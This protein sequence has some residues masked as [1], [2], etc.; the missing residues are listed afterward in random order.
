LSYNGVRN[1]NGISEKRSR[2]GSS[3]FSDITKIIFAEDFSGGNFFSEFAKAPDN[4]CALSLNMDMNG[5]ALETRNDHVEMN[6]SKALHRIPL[7]D[8]LWGIRAS[9]LYPMGNAEVKKS[10]EGFSITCNF[11]A[12][13]GEE[14]RTPGFYITKELNAGKYLF[15]LYLAEEICPKIKIYESADAV[16]Y[17]GKPQLMHDT[18][19]AKYIQAEFTAESIVRIEI[20][21]E[22]EAAESEVHEILRPMLLDIGAACE[23]GADEN[24]AKSSFFE[25]KSTILE[26]EV[27]LPE[28]ESEAEAF[29]GSRYIFKRGEGL[30]SVNVKSGECFLEYPATAQYGACAIYRYGD[31]FI[32]VFKNGDVITTSDFSPGDGA[33]K[34]EIYTPMYYCLYDPEGEVPY[35]QIEKLNLFNEYFYVKLL[36]GGAESCRLPEGVFVDGDF[37]EAYDPKNMRRLAEGDVTLKINESGEATLYDNSS[38]YGAIVKLRLSGKGREAEKIKKCRELL[39]NPLGSEVFPAASGE[40]HNVVLYGGENGAEFAVCALKENMYSTEEEIFLAKNTEKVTSVLRYSENFLVFSPHYIRK[41]VVSEN[42]GA[43]SAELQNFKYDIGCDIPGSAVC[44]DDKI[45]YANSRAGIFCIDRFGFTQ[46]DMSRH[47]SSNIEA[48]ENGFLSCSEAELAGAEAAVCA[49]KYFLR[50]GDHFYIWDFAY[51]APTG[52]E[53]ASEERK[54]RWIMYSGVPC[55]KMLGADSEKIYFLTEEGMLASI[56]RG[57]SL[58]SSA[59]SYFRSGNYSLEPFGDAAVWKLSLS[60]AAKEPCTVRLYFDGEEGNAKYTVA[61]NGEENTLCIVRPEARKCRRFAFSLHS[62]GAV[63][64]EGFKIEYLPR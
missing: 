2:F 9:E 43:F 23:L 48:G 59:E 31:G 63:R 13:P 51:A 16:Y 11:F 42:E 33:K 32:A 36:L 38:C 5:N 30:F 8:L 24:N 35:K 25:G 27:D 18:S 29:S 39:F 44:A 19:G 34:G 22:K 28:G 15:R 58:S 62:F 1:I 10:E 52:T 61:P 53:K 37:C 56:S 46:K 57:T 21:Y 64:L 3:A 54:L 41:M 12:N 40:G 7:N 6:I 60:L 26:R 45:I 17:D 55:R 49:G 14:Y 50:V 47:V 4:G 20:Y